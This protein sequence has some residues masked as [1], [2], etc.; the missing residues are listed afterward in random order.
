MFNRVAQLI[1]MVK[2]ICVGY[3]QEG[4]N[5]PSGEK[6]VDDGQ[7]LSPTVKGRNSFWV[8]RARGGIPKIRYRQKGA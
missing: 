1:K 7:T 3:Q 4:M 2:K 8:C 5:P 6:P